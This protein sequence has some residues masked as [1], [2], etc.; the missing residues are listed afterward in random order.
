[1]LYKVR[2]INKKVQLL[3]A[4]LMLVAVNLFFLPQVFATTYLTKSSVILTNMVAGGTS[5]VIFEFTTSASNTGTTLTIQFPQYTGSS[6]GI[7]NTTQTYAQTYTINSTATNCKT[8]TGASANLPGTPTVAGS[9]T[10]VTFTSMTA[11]TGNTSY[12]G[13]LTSTSAVTNPTSPTVADTAIITAGADAAST[14][15]L[16]VISNDT[17]TVN[18]TVPPTFTFGLGTTSDTFPTLSPTAIQVTPG[19]T[20]TVN[21][22]AKN[23]WF[24]WGSDGAVS[25][26]LGLYSPTQAY[27][28]AWSSPGTNTTITST[29]EGYVTGI[30]S[31]SITQ[32]GGSATPAA[33]TAYASSGSGNGAGLDNS[34]REMITSAGT[35][36]NAQFVVKEYAGISSITPAATDY[37]DTITLVGAGSF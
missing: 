14:V 1:M 4:A 20:V 3:L 36:N 9:S 26:Q 29:N 30:A 11:L 2:Q 33:T 34:N 21:T 32:T 22:N 23:G 37:T 24:V 18:A 6:A 7:V 19:V 10:T 16:D 25:A 15:S 27:K 12:C 28:I 13:V 31:G 8:I 35:A 5:S 17:I